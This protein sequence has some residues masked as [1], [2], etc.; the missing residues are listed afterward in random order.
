MKIECPSCHLSGKVNELELPPEGRELK[1]PR[2]KAAFHVNKP[3][4]PAGKQYLMSI[5]PVCQ[6]STFTDEMFAVCPKCGLVGNEYRQNMR[7]QKDN[8]QMRRDEELL[9]RSHRNPDLVA[10]PP[11][12]TISEFSS[13][14]Q[15]VRVTGWICIA[16]GAVLLLYGLNGLLTYYSKDWQA[17][18][19]EQLLEPISE[20]SVFFRLG[21]I[22]WLITLFS[23]YFIV[24]ATLFL[25][26]RTGSL[27]RLKECAWAGLGLG[28]IHETVDFILWVEISSSSPSFYYLLTG[29]LSS[30]FW[31]ALWSAPAI[32]LLWYLKNGKIRREFPDVRSQS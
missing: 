6:Y 12:E 15:P 5:C 1:C 28:V 20:S 7:K 4:P 2:C 24:T 22:P 18:L 27:Q 11:D 13:A 19:S 9:T 21:F 31:I 10:P 29:I 3:P 17:V 14:P 8:E 25:K 32:A 30:L 26:L 16:T 23:A